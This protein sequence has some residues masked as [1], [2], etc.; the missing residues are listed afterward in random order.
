MEHTERFHGGG[1]GLAFGKR[2]TLGK[3][4][5]SKTWR[6]IRAGIKEK[7]SGNDAKDQ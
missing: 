1:I 7:I 5:T 3:A 4:E 6:D 2:L